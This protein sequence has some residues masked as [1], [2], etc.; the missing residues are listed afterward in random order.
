[1]VRRVTLEAEGAS[2][3]PQGEGG[4]GGAEKQRGGK[5]VMTST[6]KAEADMNH[7]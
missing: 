4:E 1:M 7:R 6:R 5:E 2:V 3:H